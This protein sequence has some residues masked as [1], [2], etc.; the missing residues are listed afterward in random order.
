MEYQ[1]LED[2]DANFV[3]KYNVSCEHSEENEDLIQKLVKLESSLNKKELS[4]NI[5]IGYFKSFISSKH[6]YNPL[7]FKEQKK[8]KISPIELND[9]EMKFVEDLELYLGLEKSVEKYKNSEIFLL[10]NR[11]KIGVGFFEDGGF[12]PDFIM[13]ILKD[14]KQYINFIDPKGIRNLD[15]YKNKKI[16]FYKSIKEKE[17]YIGDENTVLN[18][19][20]ISNTP[21]SEL[22][23][24]QEYTTKIELENKNVL[25]QKD[26][27]NNYIGKMF[28]KILGVEK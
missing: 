14:S 1:E 26:D 10:R 13:W 20:I 15:L 17:Q 28:S 2:D 7:L 27:K 9:G 8:I 19:F 12:Y 22:V 24:I 3:E 23:N 18:S 25:F 16:N 5:D 11:S 4:Y 6:L 21:Y